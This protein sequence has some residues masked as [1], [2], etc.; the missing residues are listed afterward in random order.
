MKSKRGCLEDI[1]TK[2]TGESRWMIPEWAEQ[3]DFQTYIP[4]EEQDDFPKEPLR[5]WRLGVTCCNRCVA[6]VHHWK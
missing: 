4:T 2:F 5:R 6:R 1:S 3:K